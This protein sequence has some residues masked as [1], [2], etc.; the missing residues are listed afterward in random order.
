MSTNTFSSTVKLSE[1]FIKLPIYKADGMNLIFFCDCFL[2]A[3]DAAG[4]SDHFKDVSTTMELTAPAVADLKNPTADKTKAMSKYM[5]KCQI[6]KSEQAVIKQG[7][8]SVILD[9]L[10]LNAKGE[11]TVK[12]MWEKIKLEYKKKLKMIMVD[13]CWKLQ[14]E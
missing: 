5:K 1:Y 11:A 4:L 10:F 2:F 12:V 8:I 14:D 9:S 3:V 13:L 6:W 7:I